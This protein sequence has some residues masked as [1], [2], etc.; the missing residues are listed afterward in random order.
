MKKLLIYIIIISMFLIVAC[1]NDNTGKTTVPQTTTGT[2]SPT[3]GTTGTAGTTTGTGGTTTKSLTGTAKG[4]G[5][6]VVATVKVNGKDI[7]SV[8]IVGDKETKD[9]GTKAIQQL[10]AKIVAADSTKVDA[11]SG[12]TVTSNAIKEAVDKALA[13]NK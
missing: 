5:G 8:D 2:Q 7:V 13:N 1:T 6:D 11:V 3:T 9:V 12:A 4:Y 10:P